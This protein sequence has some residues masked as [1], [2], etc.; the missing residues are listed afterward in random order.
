M[1]Q[2]GRGGTWRRGG[3]KAKG[4]EKGG[5]EAAAPEGGGGGASRARWVGQNI[6]EGRRWGGARRDG[7]GQNKAE[8]AAP[9]GGRGLWGEAGGAAARGGGAAGRQGTAF[10]MERP[11][12]RPKRKQRRPRAG[13]R[14]SQGGAGSMWRRGSGEA[15]GG[16]LRR[17]PHPRGWDTITGRPRGCPEYGEGGA[18]RR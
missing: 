18:G 15:K 16:P 4:C 17:R 3:G 9:P 8:E 1:G 11:A 7:M 2:C 12:D 10:G 13:G 5:A 14:R 6:E